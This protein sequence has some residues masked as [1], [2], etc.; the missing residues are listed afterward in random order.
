MAKTLDQTLSGVP[1]GGSDNTDCWIPHYKADFRPE[2]QYQF[3][4]HMHKYTWFWFTSE[5]SD[6]VLASAHEFCFVL[7]EAD[8]IICP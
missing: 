5:K 7:K 1:K 8:S 4:C 2:D 3:N 6:R